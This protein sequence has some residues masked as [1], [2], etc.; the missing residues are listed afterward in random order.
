MLY[1]NRKILSKWE[2]KNFYSAS[3]DYFTVLIT[4][5]DR[6]LQYF[7]IMVL[8]LG[9]GIQYCCFVNTS[10]LLNIRV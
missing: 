8:V 10:V 5:I 2:E 4:M 6:C 1:E 3:F 9:L 7:D